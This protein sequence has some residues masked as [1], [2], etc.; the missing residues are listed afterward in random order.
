MHYYY[1]LLLNASGII[2]TCVGALVVK[3]K[4]PIGQIKREL[5]DLVDK[6]V[7]GVD[8]VTVDSILADVTNTHS[9][10]I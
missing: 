8:T 7:F 10:L 2:I 3:R 9:E 5:S 1:L 4:I 6:A